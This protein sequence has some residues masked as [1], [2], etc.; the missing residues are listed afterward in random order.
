MNLYDLVIIGAGPAALTAA[1]YAGRA[2]LKT[3]IIE[4]QLIGGQ[5]A[6]IDMIDNY[7]GYADGVTGFE[8]AQQMEAQAK[9]FGAEIKIGTV[10]GIEN[11]E[12]GALVKCDTGDVMART[13]LIATGA[14]HRHL[15]IPGEDEYVHYCATCDGAFYKDKELVSVGG[16]NSAVQ[17]VLFLSGIAKHITMLVRSYIK[18]DQILKDR[19]NQTIA[20]GKV[21]LMEGWRPLEIM[22]SDNQVTG[23][24]ATNDTDNKAI[25]ADG[26]FVFA[27][28]APNV[29][30]LFGS[31]VKLTDDHYIVT[32]DNQRTT[33]PNVWAAGDVRAGTTK[34]IV[35]AAADG[36]RAVTKVVK[37]LQGLEK[38]G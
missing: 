28:Y 1:V 36:A 35:N 10:T 17:E 5:V 18:A 4:Q 9:R 6:T 21:T 7:P 34:Q 30:F 24:R 19:L 27:G 14:G 22:A 3:L 29:R 13:A 32:D 20:G 16:A 25:P 37:Y 38:N 26:V 12:Q 33:M 2:G 23:V 31:A 8:L 15:G 11:T